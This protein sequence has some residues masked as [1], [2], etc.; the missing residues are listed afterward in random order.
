MSRLLRIIWNQHFA[1]LRTYR[2]STSNRS[3]SSDSEQVKLNKQKRDDDQEQSR[4][5][6][7]PRQPH[8]SNERQHGR[9]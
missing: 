1:Y 3:E 6:L 8:K 2:A 7:P 9:R 4:I 5:V